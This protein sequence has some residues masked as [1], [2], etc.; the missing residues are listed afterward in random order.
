MRVDDLVDNDGIDTLLI[1][2]FLA[3]KVVVNHDASAMHE[4]CIVG[5][6]CQDNGRKDK[7]CS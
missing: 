1:P 3:L 2:V 4:C 6:V 5:K 7:L